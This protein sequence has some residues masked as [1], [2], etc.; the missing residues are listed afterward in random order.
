MP[1]IS[2]GPKHGNRRC[3]LRLSAESAIGQAAVGSLLAAITRFGGT[4]K[5][6]ESYA[7]FAILRFVSVMLEN[8]CPVTQMVKIKGFTARAFSRGSPFCNVSLRAVYFVAESPVRGAQ[9]VI[10]S[11][12]RVFVASE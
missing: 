9:K 4:L 5:V 11:E 8:F 7:S 6:V 3:S 12:P 10:S 1:C 2:V